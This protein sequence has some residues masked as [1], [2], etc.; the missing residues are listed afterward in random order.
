MPISHMWLVASVLDTPA[1]DHGF[2]L[3]A[4]KLLLSHSLLSVSV[5]RHDLSKK[6]N[7]VNLGLTK[8]GLKTS[9]S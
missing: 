2:S 5:H 3:A 6:K 1:L 7:N 8:F 9:L 4:L